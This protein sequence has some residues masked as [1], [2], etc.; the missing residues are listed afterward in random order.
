MTIG[1]HLLSCRKKVV[2]FVKH[3]AEAFSYRDEVIASS[4]LFYLESSCE[5][6]FN[7]LMLITATGLTIRYG[8]SKI[9]ALQNYN[10]VLSVKHNEVK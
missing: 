2:R 4:W 1:P 5:V 7:E 8:V 3:D 10:S 9:I 6:A